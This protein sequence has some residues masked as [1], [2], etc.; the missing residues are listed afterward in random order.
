M[1]N[2]IKNI[3]ALI[4]VFAALFVTIKLKA[5]EKPLIN[6]ML[7]EISGNGL[8]QPSYLFGTIHMICAQ[9][10]I[11]Q[12]KVKRS[13][14]KSDRYIMEINLGDTAELR[15]MQALAIGKQPLSTTLPPADFAF[16]DSVLQKKT[17]ISLKQLDNFTLLG[18]NGLLMTKSLPCTDVKMYEMELLAL[19][20]TQNKLTGALETVAEQGHYFSKGS[21]DDYTV[22]QLKLMDDY[23]MTFNKM[24]S[25]YKMEQVQ[26]LYQETTHE[27][28][29]DANAKKWMLHERNQNWV[30]RMPQMMAAHSNFF[31]VGAAHLAGK[32]GLI[33]L[34][35]AKG[36]TV[37]PILK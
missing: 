29:M 24:V 21:P 37:K 12:D 1:K 14:A 35:I 6:S 33:A 19:A 22:S 28:Y 34:L 15:H 32:D 17:A 25:A 20:K 13:L 23:M 10:F 9:D 3:I 8:Q 4:A 16:L 2:I 31:A 30:E 5:Q 36:Y 11:L 27:K 18:I 26:T 7:W